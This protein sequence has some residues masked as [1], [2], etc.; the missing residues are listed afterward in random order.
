M[1][2]RMDGKTV[3]IVTHNFTIGDM[4]DRVIHLRGGEIFEIKTS[5]SPT[6]PFQLRW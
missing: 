5:P 6:D 3:L 4:A 2:N 1:I